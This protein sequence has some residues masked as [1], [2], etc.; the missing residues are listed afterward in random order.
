MFGWNHLTQIIL[1]ITVFPKIFYSDQKI[2]CIP[3]LIYKKYTSQ[4]HNRQMRNLSSTDKSISEITSGLQTHKSASWWIFSSAWQ[5][6]F[7]SLD[8]VIPDSDQQ[9]SVSPSF[10]SEADRVF[11]S[12]CE[13]GGRLALWWSCRSLTGRTFPG[14]LL[15]QRNVN[16]F[17]GNG[18]D[19]T[20]SWIVHIVIVAWK[21]SN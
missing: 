9:R 11:R 1:A 8:E 21:W 6:H 20:R 14:G 3:Y 15:W 10:T 5:K 12:V 2:I 18:V 17:P 7:K 19:E 4:N 13:T 16:G